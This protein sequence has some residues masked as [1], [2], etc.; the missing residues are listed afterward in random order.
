[1][2]R[3][4]RRATVSTKRGAAGSSPSARRIS[5][6]PDLE[7]ASGDV[8]IRTP[9]S[10]KLLLRHDLAAVF[11]QATEHRERLRCERHHRA[12]AQEPLVGEIHG[13]AFERQG[14]I[15]VH[16]RTGHPFRTASQPHPDFCGGPG[17]LASCPVCEQR[18]QTSYVCQYCDG[19]LLEWICG[20]DS[21]TSCSGA[22]CN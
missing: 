15:G 14:P 2:K 11:S 12:L 13:V 8:R 9:R 18:P 7:N 5:R 1:M 10:K 16:R 22:S 17:G 3:W 20:I 6:I 19:K 21:C 4:P